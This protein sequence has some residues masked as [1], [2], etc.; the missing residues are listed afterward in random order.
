MFTSRI[1]RFAYFAEMATHLNMFILNCLLLCMVVMEEVKPAMA[2]T[3]D[4]LKQRTQ[5]LEKTVKEL[6]ER[7]KEQAEMIK[8]LNKCQGKKYT[9]SVNTYAK[10]HIPLAVW[11]TLE[12][13]PLTLL[14]KNNLL[15]R[16]FSASIRNFCHHV[17]FLILRETI[18]WTYYLPSVPRPP[19]QPFVKGKINLGL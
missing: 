18:C 19:L 2:K 10:C 4:Q 7:M 12:F 11:A 17:L 3:G 5:I 8:A 16:P 14:F 13:S 6:D 1:T 15:Q 9:P